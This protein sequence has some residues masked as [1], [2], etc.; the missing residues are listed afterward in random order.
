MNYIMHLYGTEVPEPN[1]ALDSGPV[2][3]PTLSI[4]FYSTLTNYKFKFHHLTI[5]RHKIPE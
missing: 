4:S 3:W 5:A 2:A 1:W